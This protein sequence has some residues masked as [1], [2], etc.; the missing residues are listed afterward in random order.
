ML[1]KCIYALRQ[2]A[3]ATIYFLSVGWAGLHKSHGK[4][5]FGP[6]LAHFGLFW[7]FYG[8]E[9]AQKLPGAPTKYRQRCVKITQKWGLGG[10]ES[11]P[12]LA[13]PPFGAIV[14]HFCLAPV[15]SLRSF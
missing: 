4:A 1:A 8:S 13:K 7:P 5:F 11:T 15:G 12:G 2:R 14:T 10:G 3:T 9:M 6:Y